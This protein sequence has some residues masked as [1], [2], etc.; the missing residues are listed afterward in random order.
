MSKKIFDT[1]LFTPVTG[2]DKYLLLMNQLAHENIQISYIN[3]LNEEILE[4]SLSSGVK[5]IFSLD[6]DIIS[7]VT[8]L[9]LILSRFRIEGRKIN[10]IDLRFK[11]AVVE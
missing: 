11:N 7:E 2:K 6:K 9:Q 5:V 8:S 3:Y 1:K 4:A 10:R